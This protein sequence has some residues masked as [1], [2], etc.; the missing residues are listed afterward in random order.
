MSSLSTEQI[1]VIDLSPLFD[2]TI[3]TASPTPAALALAHQVDAAF[4]TWGFFIAKELPKDFLDI[5]QQLVR[6]LTDFFALPD[7]SKSKLDLRTG[8]WPWRGYMPFEGEAT[9]GRTDQKEGFYGG[10]EHDD[11][12]PLAGLPTYGKNLFPD[13]EVPAMRG[14]VLEYTKAVTDIGCLIC[15]LISVALGLGPSYVRSNLLEKPEPVQLFRAFHYIGKE[16]QKE[17]QFGIGRHSD[18]GL[19]TLLSTHG[20]GL[21]VQ[22][23]DGEGWTD[24]PQIPGSLVINVG[25]ILD[26][27]T[28]GVYVSRPHRVNLPS[29]STDRLSIPFF[30][31]PAWNAEITPFP[32]ATD[33]QPSEETVKLAEERWKANT[34]FTK[35]QGVWGQYLGVK[36]Q[37]VFPELSLPPF[38]AV[39]R[40]S[41]R[42]VL[43]VAKDAPIAVEAA[44]A[45]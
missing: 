14:A 38:D 33:Q 28:S 39:Q 12:H 42:H 37:K 24:V 41:T 7:K 21:Q 17:D 13:D 20:P 34:T 23:L 40:G 10:P 35:L 6:A 9:K 29:P 26:R 45:A 1:P 32:L 15:D 11:D 3:G 16:G 25:D 22:S 30:F 44:A 18:F 8:G 2:A 31:D 19:L 36:V 4:R 43:Q 5:N 27:L